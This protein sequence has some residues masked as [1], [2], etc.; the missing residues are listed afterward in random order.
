MP[1][2]LY[3]FLIV[4]VISGGSAVALESPESMRVMHVDGYGG[5]AAGPK[6][7]PYIC[8]T[9]EDIDSTWAYA[10]TDGSGGAVTWLT[11]VVP[12]E[13]GEYVTF[14]IACGL[15]G[16]GGTVTGAPFDIYVNDQLAIT[17]HASV[18][19]STQ[20][21]QDGCLATFTL[22]ERDK[23]NDP[24][25]VLML[26]L[27]TDRVQPGSRATMRVQSRITSTQHDNAYFMLN[28]VPNMRKIAKRVGG[29]KNLLDGVPVSLTTQR[30]NRKPDSICLTGNATG[31]L[32]AHNVKINGQYT[33]YEGRTNSHH[34]PQVSL[35]RAKTRTD[36]FDE[37]MRAGGWVPFSTGKL[38]D[39]NDRTRIAGYPHLLQ[40]ARG[41]DIVFDFGDEYLIDG[42]ETLA[43]D[44]YVRN[45]E[46][47]LK[48]PGE[49]RWTLAYAISDRKRFTEHY[50][51]KLVRTQRMTLAGSARWV[52]INAC[53]EAAEGGFK[54]IMIWGRP[55]SGM[56]P[57]KKPALQNDGQFEIKSPSPI[58]MLKPPS[59]VCP[60]PQQVERKEGRFAFTADT[61]IVLSSG[62]SQRTARTARV[63]AADLQEAFDLDVQIGTD[64]A[65]SSG[66]IV[67]HP[68]AALEGIGTHGYRLDI[69]PQR[70][71]VT[72]V[73]EQGTFYATQTLVQLIERSKAGCII[74]AQCIQD[75]PAKPWRLVSGVL[76]PDVALLKTLAR[77]KVTHYNIG[78]GRIAGLDPQVKQTAEDRFIQA[79]PF[80]QFN[81]AYGPD[82]E[83]FIERAPNETLKD[84]NPGRR[85]PCPSHP[86]VWA[87]YFK[88]IDLA[89][90]YPSEYVNIN[91]DEMY[92]DHHG[93][94]WNV[95]SR[96]RAR[97]LS[98][99]ELLAQTIE[100]IDAYIRSKG[101]KTLMIASPFS[102]TGISHPDDKTNDWRKAADMLAKKGLSKDIALYN[103][104][105][106]NLAGRLRELGFSLTLWSL[107]IH[108]EELPEVY[109]GL[110]VTQDDAP[111]N[112]PAI[113]A[114]AQ[115][116]WSPKQALG[117][118]PMG[119]AVVAET[120]PK[121]N[122]LF[123]GMAA[124]SLRG[125]AEFFS[126]DLKSSANRT[127]HD[128]VPFDGVGWADLGPNYDL[129]ALPAGKQT[130][131]RVPFTILPDDAP[132]CVM[133]QNRHYFNRS[134]PQQV[135]IPVG[136]RAAGISFLHTLD[137]RA[138]QSYSRKQE[139][140][141][142]YFMVYEDGTYEPFE[143]KYALNICN[144][145]GLNTWWQ[146]A[147]RGETMQ[148]ARLAW[149]GELGAGN[150][151]VLYVTDWINPHPDKVI[152][153]IVMA[154]PTKPV[155]VNPILIA[156]TAVASPVPRQAVAPAA[157]AGKQ[158]AVESLKPVEPF[159]KLID[160][161]NGKAESGQVW[162]TDSGI[163]IAFDNPPKNEKVHHG[164]Q[165]YYS[166]VRQ[167]LYDSNEG[168]RPSAARSECT[169]TLPEPR[170][171]SGLQFIGRYRFEYGSKSD[172]DP[173][174]IDWEVHISTDGKQFRKVA[175]EMLYVPEEQPPV[176][177]SLKGAHIKAIRIA[178]YYHRHDASTQNGLALIKLFE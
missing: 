107:G 108:G 48:S 113:I 2:H 105:G 4:V 11:R 19:D 18:K 150:Q 111:F 81:W 62:T 98:G 85:N 164:Y 36:N 128:D 80:V 66:A 82:P 117:G 100:K 151:A 43:A 83:A 10:R 90:A 141:G 133:V 34:F 124:P 94:R 112:P 161:T 53:F 143:L 54:E 121:F 131:G 135:S 22:L 89:A 7:D 134:L 142:Y 71:E 171:L 59:R 146:T 91:M 74:P 114:M 84:L 57:A 122:R 76:N 21:E 104:H 165:P 152:D 14:V 132:S 130:L 13:I 169:I 99:H 30:R 168:Y 78:N 93:S 147:P 166:S 145:D 106:L 139:L 32:A 110:Y 58:A 68:V 177:V 44:S 102:R 27:P 173:S 77:F 29:F 158:R 125:D 5:Q 162:V 86:G 25:G 23:W 70:V 170:A 56:R 79:I 8:F 176:W 49:P 109:D 163:R 6:T 39:A 3:I 96:C 174:V 157:P 137:D 72:G 51:P 35:H 64:A 63:F 42:L 41:I 172:F 129:R 87:S 16:K 55:M 52:R 26:T 126:I 65:E 153:R 12:Q 120:M 31:E 127:R 46:V 20:W 149:R 40:T 61:R 101:K 92:Q 154:S 67:F 140:V 28:H 24:F 159:G 156:A 9:G 75:W 148:R 103:W 97:N 50:Y 37:D 88:C 118:A 17:I 69:T 115:H 138:G 136:A 144:F 160:L 119:A 33:Y 38:T 116:L 95:C 178:T 45:I 1:R 175:S 123:N 47:Y 167:I 73:D 155:G 60:L 15:G